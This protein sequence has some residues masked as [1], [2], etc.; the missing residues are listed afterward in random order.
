MNT[1]LI[2]IEMQAW[3]EDELEK[4]TPSPH[5]LPSEI[6]SLPTTNS[7]RSIRSSVMAGAGLILT[8]T[9]LAA[10]Q[11]LQGQPT[12]GSFQLIVSPE[13]LSAQ[14]S[15]TPGPALAQS[16]QGPL[17]PQQ[18]VETLKSPEW[19]NPV[20]EKLSK[21]YS[22]LDYSS[23]VN[24]LDINYQP[25]TGALKVRYRDRDSQKVHDVLQ[26]LS[27]VYIQHR[28]TC[29]SICQESQFVTTQVSHLQ[30][31][32]EH[33]NAELQTLQQSYR[34]SDVQAQI[35]HLSTAKTQLDRQ[36]RE[37]ETKL[38]GTQD[39]YTVLQ[40]Q[41]QTPQEEAIA[42]DL[43]QHIPNYKARI[44]QL[45]A[46]DQQIALET[47][48]PQPDLRRLQ[49]L[50]KQRQAQL[51]DLNVDT[52]VVLQQHWSQIAAYFP[53]LNWKDP[54]TRELLDLWLQTM[55]SLQL[56]KKQHQAIAQVATP[57]NQQ[58]AQWNTVA[59][60]YAYLQNQLQ[61]AT[62]TLNQ[63]SAKQETLKPLAAQYNVAWQLVT[64][65]EIIPSVVGQ[66]APT[67]NLQGQKG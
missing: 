30:R 42:T 54:N 2:S 51:S 41:L 19:L 62:T 55:H 44:V 18:Q 64:P 43:F 16:S 52:D 47:V 3:L 7:E 38:A 40:R 49:T 31:H 8:A 1:P 35:Q 59:Q 23:L 11:Q 57:L 12:E 20:V 15:A 39:L 33:L 13:E 24:Q 65:P 4:G 10:M 25:V 58:L 56:Q 53:G 48:Q 37:V 21:Q 45:Q 26:A 34:L 32:V 46:L 36:Q 66:S 22:D 17:N 50:Q 6:P 5:L 67:S 29:P 9:S 63:Y 61:V 27:Q 60:R 14:P 28:P